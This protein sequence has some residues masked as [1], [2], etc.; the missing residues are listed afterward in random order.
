[1][2]HLS[3]KI[4]VSLMASS[5]I[6]SSINAAAVIEGTSGVVR[7]NSPTVAT[8][9]VTDHATIITSLRDAEAAIVA[10]A[11]AQEEAARLQKEN[12]ALAS[13]AARLQFKNVVLEAQQQEQR[14]E[15][16]STWQ[17]FKRWIST[18]DA[19]HVFSTI[20]SG[21]VTILVTVLIAVL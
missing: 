1:M 18:L 13:K 21:I 15:K 2:K 9:V 7:D 4:A 10:G 8:S 3:Q 20:A 12:A 17:K 11:E 16:A 19:R 5:M 6:V 14:A